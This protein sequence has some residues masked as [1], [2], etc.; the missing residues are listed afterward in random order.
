MDITNIRALSIDD[1]VC[2][3]D[4]SIQDRQLKSNDINT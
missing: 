4:P 3:H 1:H 2:P